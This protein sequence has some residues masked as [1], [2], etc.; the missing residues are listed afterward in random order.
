MLVLL[1]KTNAIPASDAEAV[2]QLFQSTVRCH[3]N[4][5]LAV[6]AAWAL[7][8]SVERRGALPGLRPGPGRMHRV[9]R[10]VTTIVSESTMIVN[11]HDA[12]FVD[13]RNHDITSSCG[14]ILYTRCD[15]F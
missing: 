15:T 13:C 10:L 11:T 3:P 8:Y 6:L 4:I 9:G 5:G 2:S 12:N 7:A 14:E 1:E